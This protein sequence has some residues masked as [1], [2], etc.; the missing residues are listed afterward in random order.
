[1]DCSALSNK[2]LV[3]AAG[4]RVMKFMYTSKAHL[5]TYTCSHSF[6]SI[7]K[8]EKDARDKTEREFMAGIVY[9]RT[10]ADVFA[11]KPPPAAATP[12][13]TAVATARRPR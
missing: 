9:E 6:G 7:P 13:P 11:I 1:M 5:K 4:T 3:H 2:K 12:T 10:A 8:E